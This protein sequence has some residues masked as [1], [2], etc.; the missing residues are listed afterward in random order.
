[1]CF[2]S[3]TP[4]SE[5]FGVV[6]K[7]VLTLMSLWLG[8][9]IARREAAEEALRGAL[10]IRS[11]IGVTQ[12]AVISIDRDGRIVLFNPAAERMFGYTKQEVQGK[13]ISMI[14]AEPYASEHH[15]YVERYE[16]TGEARAIGRIRAVAAKRKNGEV[17]P[18]ELSVAELGRDEHVRYAAFIRDISD[19]VKLQSQLLERERLASIGTMAS[20]L[21]HEIGNPLN[22]MYLHVQILERRLRQREALDE[23]VGD[24]VARV[25][26]EIRRLMKLLDEFRAVSRRQGLN[27]QWTPI[28]GLIN[29]VLS[30]IRPE[31]M[32][33]SIR[34]IADC[35]NDLYGGVDAEKIKQVLLNL[36]KNSLEAMPRGG[37]LTLVGSGDASNVVIRVSDTGAGIQ[38]GMDV[39]EPFATTK[40]E[41]TG[42]GLAISRQL[43]DVHGGTLSY[44]SVPGAGTCFNLRL[45]ARTPGVGPRAR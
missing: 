8:S 44:T 24:P 22:N 19:K 40:P 11:L 29:E 38:E 34:V 39:F 32:Q 21:A 33:H 12:D 26:G 20:M 16:R 45:P 36:C 9:E 7:E 15:H 18:I 41:G 37:T 28:S 13:N 23:S 4:R 2:S 1:L 31:A 6:D 10:W 14:M 25:I 30:V 42:L 27:L 3:A 5:P 43:V 17:F 35:P